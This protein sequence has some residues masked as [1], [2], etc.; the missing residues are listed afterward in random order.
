MGRDEN[1]GG[2]AR[3]PRFACVRDKVTIAHVRHKTVR[4]IGTDREAENIPP[5]KRSD[6]SRVAFLLL[7]AERA[8]ACR[9]RAYVCTHR[10]RGDLRTCLS[11]PYILLYLP[12]A[13]GSVPGIVITECTSESPS[14]TKCASVCP[15]LQNP[16]MSLSRR[17]WSQ[18]VVIGHVIPTGVVAKCLSTDHLRLHMSLLTQVGREPFS[19]GRC[20]SI[21]M[22]SLQ[23]GL[24]SQPKGLGGLG[25]NDCLRI[26]AGSTAANAGTSVSGWAPATC[27]R[28]ALGWSVRSLSV[29]TFALGALPC[30]DPAC[31]STHCWG[32]EA[33]AGTRTA[34]CETFIWSSL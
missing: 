11:G 24:V 30:Q 19:G 5:F 1:G 26:L 28:V 3:F 25:L 4:T 9:Q 23:T 34:S 31:L 32:P 33:C 29:C 21:R 8:E 27:G 22:D 7:T 20:T 14:C 17:E 15:S 13:E 18:R 10:P 2:S 12:A 6:I 16:E